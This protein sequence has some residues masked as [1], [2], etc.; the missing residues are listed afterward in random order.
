MVFIDWKKKMQVIIQDIQPKS[1]IINKA[2][3]YE[4]QQRLFYIQKKIYQASQECN[5]LLVQSLQKLLLSLESIRSLAEDLSKPSKSR[6]TINQHTSATTKKLDFHNVDETLATWCLEAE[7]KPKI[8]ASYRLRYK[9]SHIV[10]WSMNNQLNLCLLHNIDKQYLLSKMQS[11]QWIHKKIDDNLD[12]QYFVQERIKIPSKYKNT[13]NFK[14]ADL[15]YLILTLGMDWNYY[16]QKLCHDSSKHTT[17]N[18]LL[19]EIYIFDR[20]ND[21]DIFNK[22][23]IQNFLYNIGIKTFYFLDIYCCSANRIRHTLQNIKYHQA[24]ECIGELMLSV[25]HLLY[26]KNHLGRYRIQFHTPTRNKINQ[27]CNVIHNW[28]IHYTKLKKHLQTKDLNYHIFL[29]L[30]VWTKKSKSKINYQ[31]IQHLQSSLLFK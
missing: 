11:I 28:A 31:M 18:C 3:K 9:Y 16:Q 25:K 29:I 5:S 30:D 20:E 27:I 24:S 7:W 1:L 10:K 12:K 6:I 21:C 22:M 14:L 2:L 15:L 13:I 17:Y 8:K 23:M 19:D 4:R 26:G